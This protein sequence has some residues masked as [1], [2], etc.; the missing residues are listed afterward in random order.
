MPSSDDRRRD[1][2]VEITNSV[3]AALRRIIRAIDLHS[4][5][6]VNRFGLT[7]PQLVILKELMDRFPKSVGE[8]ALSVNLSQATVTT[9]LDRLEKHELV[10]RERSKEDKRKVH[11][12]LTDKGVDVLKEAPIPLQ[13]Q[14]A[15]Q[16]DDLLVSE[17]VQV[18][19]VAARVVDLPEE[20]ADLGDLLLR[21]QHAADLQPHALG[22]PA[23][24]RFQHLADIHA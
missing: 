17:R 22:G 1:A 8:L 15:R 21:L 16:F 5:T 20:L 18:F 24:V 9:I 4:R 13:E 11:A 10:Y 7:G 6:L 2:K 12:Y 3:M 14:F 19:L 23:E